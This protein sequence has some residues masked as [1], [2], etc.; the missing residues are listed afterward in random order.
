MK[1]NFDYI[2]EK[3]PES[4]AVC[5]IFTYCPHKLSVTA[6]NGRHKNCPLREEK[7]GLDCLNPKLQ[8]LPKQF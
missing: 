6:E 8:L 7:T 2:K 3:M 1:D 4:C 5:S